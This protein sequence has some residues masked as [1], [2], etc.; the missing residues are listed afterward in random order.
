MT[1]ALA[2]MSACARGDKAAD[3][4]SA[5]DSSSAAATL[6]GAVAAD[7][8][9]APGA[10]TKPLSAYTGDEFHA[11]AQS[12][13]FGGGAE[14]PRTCHK[15]AGCEVKGGKL[16]AARV[17]AV[18]G[19]ESLGVGQLGANGVI[20][21]RARVTGQHEEAR[22]NMR[23]GAFEYYVVLVPDTAGTTS[24]R[25]AQL[26]TTAGGR[27]LTAIDAGVF[28][29]CPPT[30]SRQTKYRA[31]FWSCDAAHANDSTMRMGLSQ[32]G[33]QDDPMWLACPTGCCTVE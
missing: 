14:Q 23:P 6:I 16:T 11:L 17:D 15:A 26:E 21:A 33:V 8:V 2:L 31:N 4:A 22:Y 28:R 1:A 12:L 3:S 29:P 13:T 5:A 10:L 27:R 18:T 7:S 24:W 30:A 25:L 32:H 19:L 20:A 9:R